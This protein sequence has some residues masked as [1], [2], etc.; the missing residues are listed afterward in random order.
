MLIDPKD[1]EL[2]TE[3][4]PIFAEN[5]EMVADL[6]YTRL[7]ELAPDVRDMFPADLTEQSRKLSAT[8]TLAISSLSGWDELAPILA[9]LAR[10]HI[11]Y[12]VKAW[13]YAIVAQALLDTLR[14][15]EVDEATVQ[16]WNRAMSVINA[17]MIAAAYGG[18]PDE[19][20]LTHI[21]IA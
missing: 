5:G 12:G 4:R 15:A 21:E 8:L 3:T 17:H 19:S 16:A 6:F 7:F 18:R 2:I 10:R 1:V 14:G 9:S 13:H 11:V 20:G